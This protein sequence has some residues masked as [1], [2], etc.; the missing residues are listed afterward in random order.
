MIPF[1]LF[2]GVV[3]SQPFGDQVVRGGVVYLIFM[4]TIFR[5]YVCT[6]QNNGQCS[7]M[8]PKK[9]NIKKKKMK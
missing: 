4:C 7:K 3:G 9:A 6:M 2:V 8:Q 5:K 1:A